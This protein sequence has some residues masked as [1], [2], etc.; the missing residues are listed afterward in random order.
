MTIAINAAMRITA[1][2]VLSTTPKLRDFARPVLL[3]A[4]PAKWQVKMKEL[5]N[6]SALN[7]YWGTTWAGTTYARL[8]PEDAHIAKMEPHAKP[9]L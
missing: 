8:A 2:S 6:I 7:A 3:S 4:A 5:M 1:S 9:A